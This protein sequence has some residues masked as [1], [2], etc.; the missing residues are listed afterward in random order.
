MAGIAT[1]SQNSL[2]PTETNHGLRNY[3]TVPKSLLNSL[4][5]RINYLDLSAIKG[6][7]RG[8]VPCVTRRWS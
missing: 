8:P 1:G 3:S 2:F 6:L 7:N 5:K 4:L